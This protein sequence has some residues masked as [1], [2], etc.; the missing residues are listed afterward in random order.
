MEHGP[1]RVPV[2]RELYEHR[3]EHLLEVDTQ[4]TYIR[5]IEF[6]NSTIVIKA[7]KPLL[8]SFKV[9]KMSFDTALTRDL[10]IKG[11]FEPRQIVNVELSRY[12]TRNSRWDAMGWLC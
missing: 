3:R 12:S 4:D 10:G 6:T 9:T 11:N 7:S 8:F 1:Q 5:N 2:P